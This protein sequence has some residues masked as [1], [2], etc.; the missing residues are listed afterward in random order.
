MPPTTVNT[1]LGRVALRPF[2]GRIIKAGDPDRET[3][4]AIQHRLNEV[5][6]GPLEETG[7]FDNERTKTAVKLFQSRFPDVTGRPLLIDG[8]VGM[9]TWGALFGARSVPSNSTAPSP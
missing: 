8:E 2:P 4:E 9:H 1:P 3:V 7:I 6:C 5:G